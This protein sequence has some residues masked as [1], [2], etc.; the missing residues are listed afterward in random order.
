VSLQR[1][2]LISVRGLILAGLGLGLLV[3]TVRHSGT[4]LVVDNHERSD[5]IV[6]TQASSLDKP[7]WVGLYMLKDGY[8]RELLV[9]A[10]TNQVF[11]SRTQA[12]LASEFIKMT[13]HDMPGRVRVCP[14]AAAST[15]QETFE[16]EACL[17]GL[18]VRSVLL[19]VYDYHSRRSLTTFTR[20]VP[21]YRWSIAA[22][23]DASRFGTAWWLKREWA[24]TAL[25]EWEHLLWWEFVEQWMY[26][27][28]ET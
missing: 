13:A 12:D 20:L 7:Y 22:V 8:G 11:F 17:K 5:A 1:F 6:V 28:S 9:D 15:V 14:I 26:R 4:F 25:V 24:R 23:P 18:S 27:P 16:V 21:Q 3:V 10:R 2:R 19:V